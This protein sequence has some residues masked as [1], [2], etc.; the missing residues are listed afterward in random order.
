[1]L[2]CAALLMSNV[3][4]FN[5]MSSAEAW[6]TLCWLSLKSSKHPLDMKNG[7]AFGLFLHDPHT[8]RLCCFHACS[9]MPMSC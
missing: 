5:P 6:K 8:S 9:H 4:Y 7:Y 3:D 1:M 2:H